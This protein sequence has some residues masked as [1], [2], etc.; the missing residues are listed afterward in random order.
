MVT[1]DF[2]RELTTM[3]RGFHMIMDSVSGKQKGLKF[4]QFS[5]KHNL[6]QW[7]CVIQEKKGL[8]EGIYDIEKS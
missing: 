7:I 1:P 3:I 8:I 4:K 6:I 5:K 2:L